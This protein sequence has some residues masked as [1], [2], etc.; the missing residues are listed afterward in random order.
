[1]KKPK[2]D[3]IVCLHLF[4]LTFEFIYLLWVHKLCGYI[5]HLYVD[6]HILYV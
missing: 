1:M 3:C 6:N 5:L 4:Q 2:I